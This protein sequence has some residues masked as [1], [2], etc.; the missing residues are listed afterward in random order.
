MKLHELLGALTLLPFAC[1]APAKTTLPPEKGDPCADLAYVFFLVADA[2][3]RG[4]TKD[5]QIENMR[6]SVDNPFTARREPTLRSLLGVVD[7]V[8]LRSD[9]SAEEIRSS[10][11]SDCSV[12]EQGRAVLSGPTR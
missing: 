3:D 9:E 1:S 2:R 8:Y 10:V 4:E 5:A 11:L 12:D 6:S 7:R